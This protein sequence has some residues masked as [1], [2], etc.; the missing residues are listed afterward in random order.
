M[1]VHQAPAERP[2]PSGSKIACALS[3]ASGGS[4][5]PGRG[6]PEGCCGVKEP[7]LSAARDGPCHSASPAGAAQR[8]LSRIASRREFP[9]RRRPSRGAPVPTPPC[10]PLT[11][12]PPARRRLLAPPLPPPAPRGSNAHPYNFRLQALQTCRSAACLKR[13]QGQADRKL[14]SQAT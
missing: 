11:P 13:K 8:M 4:T 5:F 9:E 7:D 14:Y 10:P 3:I 2:T 6:S 12:P 1:T